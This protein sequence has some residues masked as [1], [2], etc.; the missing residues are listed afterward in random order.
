MIKTVLLD[1]DNTILDFHASAYAALTDAFA[2][3]G[4]AFSPA[5]RPIFDEINNALWRRIEDGTLTREQLYEERFVRVFA[6]LGIDADGGMAEKTF[7]RRI[8]ETAFPVAGAIDLLRYLYP[9]YRLAVASNSVHTQ[10]VN[11]L[12][13]AGMLPYFTHLFT[14]EKIGVAKPDPAFFSAILTT[15]ALPPEEVILI[16]DSLNADIHGGITAGIQTCWYNPSGEPTDPATPPD[17][18]V[19]TLG[20]IKG[21]L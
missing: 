10:Q 3:Q 11:R 13:L 21:I 16:G 6:A 7:R 20:E 2:E 14:S 17:Y 18:T 9:R 8:A 12:R 1:I 4:I 5:Y 19:K 15:L